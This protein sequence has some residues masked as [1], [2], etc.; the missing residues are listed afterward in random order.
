MGIFSRKMSTDRIIKRR[1][2]KLKFL[3][4]NLDT[5]EIEDGYFKNNSIM[6]TY[7]NY[8]K[9]KK[10]NTRKGHTN[11]RRKGAYGKAN[12]YSAHDLR[13]ISKEEDINNEKKSIN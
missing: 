4:K 12:N 7:V 13:Q 10:T 6:N 3:N 9:S 5:S 1:K 8:G 2:E 11:Y